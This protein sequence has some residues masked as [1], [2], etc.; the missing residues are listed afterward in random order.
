MRN[1]G[2]AAANR[3]RDVASPS[4]R[5]IS[6]RSNCS[7]N[8]RQT[9]AWARTK[10]RAGVLAGAGLA[11]A[12]GTALAQL[13]SP[14][15]IDTEVQARL[16]A[17]KSA[18]SEQD[19]L[20]AAEQYEAILKLRPDWALIHQSLGVTLHLAKRFPQSIEHLRDAV[21]LDSRLWGAFLFLGIDY[22]QIG[23]FN[24]A[25]DALEESLELNSDVADTRRW[26]GLSYSAVQRY[27]ES[28]Q[29]LVQSTGPRNDDAEA[30]FHLAR[31]YD[32]RASQ[33]FEEI[34]QAEPDSPF[35]S[36]LQ[37]ERFLAE[38]DFDRARA[39][40]IRAIRVRSDL[41][42]T[43]PAL[44]EAAS[45]DRP[46]Q[47]A[48]GSVGEIQGL[49]DAG[50]H[51]E[52]ATRT[53]KTLASDATSVE[54]RYWQGRS[55]KSLASATVQRLTEV[56]PDSYRV[57]QLAAEFHRDET[58]YEKALAAYQRA[59]SKRPDL[60][61]LRYAIGDVYWTMRRLEEAEDWLRQELERNPHHALARHRLGSL[62][63]ERGAADEALLQLKQA[64]ELTPNSAAARFDLGRAYLANGQH[65]EAVREL[66][67]SADQDPGN[68]RVHY[69]LANAYRGLGRMDEA[70][71]EL[72]L[73]QEARQRR[74]KQVQTDVGSVADDLKR[75]T[76]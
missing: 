39:E 68:D 65:S 43:L 24:D 49:F 20:A 61:G 25:V 74:L 50:R 23:K 35:V 41:A 28:I 34:G 4:P 36:L 29:H 30:L 17:A 32:G 48:V 60:P 44:S 58:E 56:A 13:S 10:L 51:L 64:V 22:Y 75:A 7:V 40:Y 9:L 5:P 66:R 69:L 53:R 3:N 72:T 18:E 71:R 62:L 1:I 73:Y 54:A 67:A 47:A 15:S 76:Q 8:P 63:L 70:R 12:L 2:M 52:V 6:V 26:L 45:D 33:L 37:A 14:E 55:Y 42:G 31:A 59:L 11:A 27:E 21:R 19:Y 38:N 46:P 16:E 57:D